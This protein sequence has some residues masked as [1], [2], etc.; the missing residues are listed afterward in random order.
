MIWI[1]GVCSLHEH[2]VAISVY[3]ICGMELDGI[4]QRSSFDEETTFCGH[5]QILSCL[6][7]SFLSIGVGCLPKKLYDSDTSID[8]R[9]TVVINLEQT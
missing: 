4:W 5:T 9:N 8:L 1:V 2:R 6:R 7:H 3:W